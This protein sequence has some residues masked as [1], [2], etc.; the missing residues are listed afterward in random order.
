MAKVGLIRWNKLERMAVVRRIVELHETNP[1][2]DFLAL[3]RRAVDVLPPPRRR[4]IPHRQSI[5]IEREMFDKLLQ[6][7]QK[8]QERQQQREQEQKQQQELSLEK[9]AI[10]PAPIQIAAAPDFIVGLNEA[11][12][13]LVQSVVNQVRDRLQSSLTQAV[14]DV[15]DHVQRT[16]KLQQETKRLTKV[17]V[18]GLKNEQAQMIAKEF[19]G[20]LAVDCRSKEENPP[21]TRRASLNAAATLVMIDFV[22]HAMTETLKDVPGLTY[23]RGGMSTLRD[24]L[25]KIAVH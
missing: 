12:L 18:V 16:L 1:G 15:N 2:M 22:S 19:D 7:K 9:Q 13:L 8:E 10:A 20:V 23:V 6:Q 17:V 21:A 3:A 5:R 4:T 14:L 25:L 11:A 24:T